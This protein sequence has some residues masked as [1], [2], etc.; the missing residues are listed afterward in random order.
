MSSVQYSYENESSHAE[1][2]VERGGNKIPKNLS[3]PLRP[4]RENLRSLIV[5]R[6]AICNA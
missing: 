6:N 5:P 2:A 4:L 3:V 1:G